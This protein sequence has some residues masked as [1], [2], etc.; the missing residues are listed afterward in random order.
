MTRSEGRGGRRRRTE[1]KRGKTCPGSRWSRGGR[2]WR[3][4][5]TSPTRPRRRGRII[6][7]AAAGRLDED[8]RVLRRARSEL[9]QSFGQPI[10]CRAAFGTV[11]RRRGASIRHSEDRIETL[12]RRRRRGKKRHCLQVR[13]MM[14]N[15]V[16]SPAAMT[17][18]KTL[19]LNR[20]SL[21]TGH[22][23]RLP[24]GLA[25]PLTFGVNNPCVG[26]G[27]AP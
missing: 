14:I 27:G 2:E 3:S 25:D 6:G 11:P 7:T 4:S 26:I 13:Q 17:L 9:R 22:H 1:R 10:S 18:V 12:L 19:K 21:L 8:R 20:V 5:T 15:P 24:S 23:P 16:D